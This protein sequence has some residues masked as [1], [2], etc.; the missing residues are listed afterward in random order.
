M[1]LV[2]LI[3]IMVTLHVRSEAPICRFG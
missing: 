1:H 2:I 3:D